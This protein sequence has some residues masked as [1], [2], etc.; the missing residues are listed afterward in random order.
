MKHNK[1]TFISFFLHKEDFSRDSNH[2]FFLRVLKSHFPHG[3]ETKIIIW[4]FSQTRFLR[5]KYRRQSAIP[6]TF[7][8]YVCMYVYVGACV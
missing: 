2:Y 7:P 5:S 1:F 6:T 3:E 4:V 8:V